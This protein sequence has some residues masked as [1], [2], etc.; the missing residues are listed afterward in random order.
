MN[1]L[2]EGI[3]PSEVIESPIL[4]VNLDILFTQQDADTLER[5]NTLQAANLRPNSDM[6]GLAPLDLL[7]AGR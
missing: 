7:L 6:K 3:I 1:L 2:P 5:V 4:D